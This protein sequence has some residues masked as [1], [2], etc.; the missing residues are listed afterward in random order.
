MF[1]Y[2]FDKLKSIHKTN[3]HDLVIIDDAFPHLLS[4][5]RIAEFNGLLQ[6]FGGAHVYSSG[7]TFKTIGDTRNFREIH[8]DYAK[9]YPEISNRVHL[10]NKKIKIS[11]PLC[12]LMF[13]NNANSSLKYI[14]KCKL[15]FVLE[16]YPGGGFHLGC[17]ES[18]KKIRKV[19]SSTFFR[20]VIVTQK[21]SYEYLISNNFCQSGQVEFIYGG[22]L[23]QGQLMRG[24]LPRKKFPIDK[25]S[26]D[27]CFVAHKYMP[28]GRDKG[29]DVFIETAKKLALRHE[30]IF[31]HVVGPFGPDDIPITEIENRI[32]FY[33]SRTTNF[34]PAFYGEMDLILSP[35]VPFLLRPGAFD[36]FPTGACV[37]AA[38]CGVAVFC[39][40][41]LNLNI[42]VDGEELVIIPR[43]ISEIEKV[44][45]E[46]VQHPEQLYRIAKNG[47]K[48]FKEVFS[49]EKQ[50]YPRIKLLEAMLL[51]EKGLS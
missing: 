40:D 5:F 14:E 50:M 47:Q 7:R 21:N 37:E 8:S 22:V 24:L 1:K 2:I 3:Y 6:Y 4:A 51:E 29:Y 10:L 31:F 27:I 12:Y 41:E 44:V 42:F 18:D 23:P 30:E 28:Q 33:G 49:Y 17:Q 48:K 45:S 15:P 34:F 32:K 19:T 36:G 25:K 26:F 13:L 9:L 38:L 35:N 11:S 43:G 20:K 16:L 46:Y 39:C